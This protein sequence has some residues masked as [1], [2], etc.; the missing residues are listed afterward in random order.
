MT[1]P[2]MYIQRLFTCCIQQSV[3]SQ[4]IIPNVEGNPK[5]SK[6]HEIHH[7]DIYSIETYLV[8]RSTAVVH[9]RHILGGAQRHT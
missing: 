6:L 2:N 8:F 1:A 7:F 5:A 4:Y 9:Q 3:T